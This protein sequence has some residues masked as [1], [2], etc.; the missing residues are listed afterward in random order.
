MGLSLDVSLY[1]AWLIPSIFSFLSSCAIIYYIIFYKPNLKTQLFHQLTI[2]LAVADII[3]SGNW[4]IGVKYSAHYHQCA[5]QEYLLQLGLVLKASI[6]VV[7]STVAIYVVK[8]HKNPR[9]LVVMRL[10]TLALMLPCALIA[11]SLYAHSARLYC[12]VE[13]PHYRD[14][15]PT[16]QRSIV[17]YWVVTIFIY[18]CAAL[19]VCLLS[20]MELQLR[21]LRLS[22][23][24]SSVTTPCRPSSFSSSSSSSLSSSLSSSSQPLPSRTAPSINHKMMT[25]ITRLRIYP[26]IFVVFW[27]PEV[28]ALLTILLTGTDQLALRHLANCSGG[29]IGLATAAS[30]FYYQEYVSKQSSPSSSSSL[31]LLLLFCGRE[32]PHRS[33]AALQSERSRGRRRGGAA[34]LTGDFFFLV[35]RV[36]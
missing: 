20:S 22:L 14:S 30:Y 24:G 17:A 33:C 5:T 27:V 3:Q 29:C 28:V 10:T 7:I 1:L 11:A 32:V 2:L 19:N 13:I 23:R 16:T 6:S 26:L 8:T 12:N 31:V 36:H 15:S 4:F 9:H 18:L 35:H 25:L 21:A 34:T